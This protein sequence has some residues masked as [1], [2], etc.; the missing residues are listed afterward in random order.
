MEKLVSDGLI[1]GVLD[2]TTT[3]VADEVVGGVM[4]GGPHRF[5]AM[6]QREVPYVISLGALDMVNFGARHTVPRQ[7]VDRQLVVHNPQV[8]LMRTTAA[9][10]R[11]IANWI[12]NKV[13]RSTAPLEILIPE[14]GVSMLDAKGEA[15]HDPEANRVLF[16][17]LEHKVR[18]TETRRITRHNCHIN[19]S[20]FAEAL[21]AAFERISQKRIQ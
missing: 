1:S 19:D 9:E 13:N 8:T 2:I 12:A 10:N 6:I 18:Q 20:G 14:Q 3:E 21:V 17:T 11:E 5:D 7:F 4:P 16:E 15:F